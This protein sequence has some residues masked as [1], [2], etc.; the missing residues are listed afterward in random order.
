[1]QHIPSCQKKVT[2]IQATA[3]EK[4]FCELV[5]VMSAPFS[6]LQVAGA[7]VLTSR[8]W[9]KLLDDLQETI[10]L[11]LPVTPVL[12]IHSE[13]LSYPTMYVVKLITINTIIG[14]SRETSG[15]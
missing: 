10:E 12:Q 5:Y 8:E 13:A 11:E 4:L 14:S 15:W 7:G 1:M 3:D 6:V 2:Q 9:R